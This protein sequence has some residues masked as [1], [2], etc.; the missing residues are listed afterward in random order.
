MTLPEPEPVHHFVVRL[1]LEDVTYTPTKLVVS[2]LS[3]NP[4]TIEETLDQEIYDQTPLEDYEI[5]RDQIQDTAREE[6][7]RTKERL[8]TLRL[9]KKQVEKITEALQYASQ[10]P[11]AESLKEAYREAIGVMSDL[12][13]NLLVTEFCH[14][15]NR[16][17]LA[18][19]EGVEE[20][21]QYI[22]E[23]LE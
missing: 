22:L 12:D 21:I 2:R 19:N 14:S 18:S 16:K 6:Y 13:K 15:L 7:K 4:W 11:E 9:S 23:T 1:V 20:L 8:T 5:Y 10:Q 3:Q 17:G